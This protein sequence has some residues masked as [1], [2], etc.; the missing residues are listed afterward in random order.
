MLWPACAVACTFK[1]GET[2]TVDRVRGPVHPESSG[3][4]DYND[5][6]TISRAGRRQSTGTLR[7]RRDIPDNGQDGWYSSHLDAPTVPRVRSTVLQPIP[8]STQARR[9]RLLDVA[10]GTESRRGARRRKPIASG[11]LSIPFEVVAAGTDLAALVVA[12]V[13]T[14]TG[15]RTGIAIAASAFLTLSYGRLYK[16]RLSLSVLDDAPIL[17]LAGLAVV[18]TPSLLRA[19]LP[20]DGVPNPLFLGV[21]TATAITVG[22]VTLY[23]VTRRLRKHYRLNRGVLI[24]GAGETGHDIAA[25]LANHPELGLRLR[26]FWDPHSQ[27]SSPSRLPPL[28][29][30]LTLAETIH[31]LRP[32]V[33]IVSDAGWSVCETVQALRSPNRL[34]YQVFVATPW[35]A[36]LGRGFATDEI[37]GIPLMRLRRS[38]YRFPM[39]EV[40]RTVDIVLASAL[41]VLTA[42][43]MLA[44]AIA[45]RLEGGPRI[46][47]RQARLGGGGSCIE[48]L[49]F[50]SMRPANERDSATTWTIDGDP[51][52]GRVG[53]VLRRTSLDELPQLWNVLRGDMA[54]VGPRPE[55]PYYVEKFAA[56]YAHY[57]DRHRLPVGMTGWAQVNG[58]RGNTSISERTRFDNYYID[59]WSLWMDVKIMLRTVAVVFGPHGELGMNAAYSDEQ[60]S[61]LNDSIEHHDVYSMDGSGDGA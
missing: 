52:V 61:F 38:R 47:F 21:V 23:S 48:V 18:V 35:A 30:P 41:L 29:R 20:L 37:W 24:A 44:I 4:A 43:L 51:R 53:R 32:S 40:K 19:L 31:L 10:R 49:K 26:A 39:P 28:S 9:A 45:V 14:G 25:A 27:D 46:I 50:R 59:N 1:W 58:L 5:A 60:P 17:A 11:R 13:M 33:V 12:S 42:P 15:S 7:D 34:A 57:A 6:V 36:G 54:L 3:E 55:R 16:P 8:P 22:R 56:K 2:M